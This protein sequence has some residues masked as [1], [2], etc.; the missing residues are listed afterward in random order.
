MSEAS[1]LK[2]EHIL[3]YVLNFISQ[4]QY[5]YYFLTTCALKSVQ[6][7]FKNA[8]NIYFLLESFDLLSFSV[9]LS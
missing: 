4:I 2:T 9:G 8:F 1:G 5:I 7:G 3:E 6:F